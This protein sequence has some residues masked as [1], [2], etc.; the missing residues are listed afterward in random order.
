MSYWEDVLSSVQLSRCSYCRIA[1]GKD[2]AERD[3]L[4]MPLSMWVNE[5][6]PWLRAQG[7]LEHGENCYH[8][9]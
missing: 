3:E 2:P 4:M 7:D 5:V 6:L 8:Y 9:T 1:D